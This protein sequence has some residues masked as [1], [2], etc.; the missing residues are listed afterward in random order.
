MGGDLFAAPMQSGDCC[1]AAICLCI[2]TRKRKS[3]R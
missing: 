3:T 1:S 2:P